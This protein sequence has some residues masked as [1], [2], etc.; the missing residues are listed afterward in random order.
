VFAM[1]Q[2]LAPVGS[3]RNDFDIYRELA[4][5]GGYEHSFTAGRTEMEWL[6]H[7]YESMTSN[8]RDNGYVAPKFDAFW[9][10]GFVEI[11]EPEKPFVLFED[12]RLDPAGKPLR[13]PSGRIELYSEKI[14][15][16]GY[17]DCPPHPAWL[18]PDEWL[19]SPKAAQ[20]PLHL[21]TPQPA[22]KLHSQMDGGAASV[23]LK[24]NGREALRISPADAKARRIGQHDL[25]KIYNDRGAC[26]ATAV[27]DSGLKPGVVVLP[28]GAWFDAADEKLEI[29]GNP[30]VLTIDVGTSRLTQ[31]SSAQSAL[32]EV[33]LWEDAAP[34]VQALN[35]P[36]IARWNRGA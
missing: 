27:I 30:N 9:S 31:G 25:V 29:H 14:A 32:V 6:R 1:H 10:Q 16:F 22:G 28:T 4:A 19:G 18:A 15:G 33:V 35:P 3:S 11:P 7:I 20:W 26:L 5:R 34:P 12:F 13:T 24:I 21:L 2:A 17:A 8:W 36:E 23:D